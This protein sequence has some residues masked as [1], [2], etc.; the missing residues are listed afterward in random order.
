MSLFERMW[1]VARSNFTDWLNNR[2]DPEQQVTRILQEM[3]GQLVMNRQA[4][5]Q[6]IA[7]QKRTERQA[8]QAQSMAD[9]WYRRASLA[10]S[11]G[12]ETLAREALSRRQV[13]LD[14]TQQKHS[15]VQQ[16]VVL[17]AQMRKNLQTLENKLIDIRNQKELLIA[18][19]RSAKASLEVNEMLDRTG[20]RE[21]MRAFERLEEKVG[22]L[23]AQVE[24]NAE[25]QGNTLESRFE[26]LTQQ[27]NVEAEL[28]AIKTQLGNSEL[29]SAS[30][31]DPELE[32][33][34]SELKRL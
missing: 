14:T 9:E 2:E 32:K 4:V 17:V 11:K 15:Q 18:R 27:K 8:H 22:N 25:L 26:A 24:V 31:P 28:T 13:Y 16:Q 30:G 7:S 34:R 1:M 23:E 3:Q 12:D 20:S 33:I 10:M 19:S 5:A 6:A 29:P 21:S